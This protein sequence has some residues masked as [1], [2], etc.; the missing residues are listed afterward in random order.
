[1]KRAN[2]KDLGVRQ[3]LA[4]AFEIEWSHLV[5]IHLRRKLMNHNFLAFILSE[6]SAFIRTGRRTS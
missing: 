4:W 5:E 1:M 6:I 2:K 3:V